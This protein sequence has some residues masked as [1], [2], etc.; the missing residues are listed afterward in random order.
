[1][2]YQ[3]FQA[4]IAEEIK[5][6]LPEKYADAVVRVEQITKNNGVTLDALQV[7]L[8][9]EYMAPSIYLNDFY[10]QHRDGRS[11]ENILAQIGKSGK[12]VRCQ[13][14]RAHV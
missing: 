8:P 14:G 12:S 5:G 4:K 13:I 6:Y 2:D 9:G 1:M 10:G 11:M 3:E 7:M